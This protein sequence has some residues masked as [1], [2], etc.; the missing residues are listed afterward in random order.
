MDAHGG[1]EGAVAVKNVA[2]EIAR[3]REDE[4][5]WRVH[6]KDAKRAKKK[7]GRRTAD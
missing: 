6:R 3:G 2:G 7:R 5:G 1:G 4:R